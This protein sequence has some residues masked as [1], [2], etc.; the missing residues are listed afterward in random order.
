MNSREQGLRQ[1][2]RDIGCLPISVKSVLS[3]D[4]GSREKGRGGPQELGAGLGEL[5]STSLA[6]RNKGLRLLPVLLLVEDSFWKKN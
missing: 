6:S 3:R 5:P 2:E 4:L 1:R